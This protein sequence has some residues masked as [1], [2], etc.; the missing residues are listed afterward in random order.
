MVSFKAEFLPKG[1]KHVP[2]II[3]GTG[4]LASIYFETQLLELIT[5]RGARTDQDHMHWILL[6]ATGTP[7]RTQ[8]LLG[9]VSDCTPYYI[10]YTKILQEAGADFIVT[11]CNSAHA[12]H[13]A[14]QKKISIPWINLIEVMSNYIHNSFPEEIKIGLLATD[15]T[16]KCKLYEKTLS[17]VGRQCIF[18]EVG[19]NIQ[20][21]IMAS[22]YDNKFGVKATGANVSSTAIE[23]FQEAVGWMQHQGAELLIAGCTEIFVGLKYANKLTLPWVDPLDILAEK[24]LNLAYSDSLE[25]VQNSRPYKGLTQHLRH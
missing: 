16:L 3:G 8:S 24:T 6:N 5:V 18:P 25:V 21:L 11:T 10:R 22:I 12:F 2:G 4:P 14:V 23:G 1:Q 7:D 13:D 17:R 9:N 19:S 20:K 15:G